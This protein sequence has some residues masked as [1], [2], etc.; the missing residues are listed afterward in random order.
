MAT[1]QN[2]LRK[3]TFLVLWFFLWASAAGAQDELNYNQYQ[4]LSWTAHRLDHM[5]QFE[6][7]HGETGMFFAI[8]E[9]LGTV[10]VVKVDGNGMSN[11]WKSNQLRG[12]PEE[13][14]TVDLDGDGLEDSILCRTTTGTVYAWSMDGYDQTWESLPGEYQTVSCFTTGNV[15]EDAATEIV[16]VADGRI[17]YVD[18]V[19]FNRQ[20]TSITEYQATQVRCGDVDGDNRMEIVLSTGQVVDSLSGEVEWEDEVFLVKIELLDVDVD[21]IS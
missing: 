3:K 5:S 15:D 1:L 13:V 7:I 17:V 12:V 20:F 11:V 19:S 16:M 9:R 6:P 18:G 21:G 14:L 8:G 4:E 10:Q 2:V